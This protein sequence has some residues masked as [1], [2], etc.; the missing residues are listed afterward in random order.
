MG[1]VKHLLMLAFFLGFAI[2][3]TFAAEGCPQ[4]EISKPEKS[5]ASSTSAPQ[6]VE[7]QIKGIRPGAYSVEDD[8]GKQF[9]IYTNSH[10]DLDGNLTIGDRVVAKIPTLTS[11]ACA[12]SINRRSKTDFPPQSY[13]EGHVLRVDGD[14]Y[15]VRDVTGKEVHLYL[16]RESRLQDQLSVGDKVQASLDSMTSVGYATFLHKR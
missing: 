8:T 1:S 16:G 4:E 11:I 15:W 5:N 9:E 13:L 12:R 10:T 7:G 3:P 2:T 6:L 14:S